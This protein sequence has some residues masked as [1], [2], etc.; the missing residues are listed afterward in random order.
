MYPVL[1]WIATAV[2]FFALELFTASFFFLWIGAGAGV[3]AI[4]A[5]F[6]DKPTVQYIT[7]AGSSILLVALSRPWAHRLSGTTK[8]A[9]NVDA[10]VGQTGIVTKVDETQ[11]S[12]GYVKVGGELWKAES[13]DRNSL[14]MNEAV[15]VVSVKGN[16]LVVKV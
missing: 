13:Q 15:K 11:P 10:L 5:F 6:I 9:A 16:L 12:Q 3:T 8:R 2:L 1:W 14:K 7:F 4:L